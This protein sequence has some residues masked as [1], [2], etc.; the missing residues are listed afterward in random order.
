[1][2]SMFDPQSPDPPSFDLAIQEA[3]ACQRNGQL[4]EAERRYRTLLRA[5]PRHAEVN[6]QLGVLAVRANQ[7]HAALPLLRTALENNP[8][9]SEYWFTYIDALNQAGQ[10]DA[11][12]AMLAQG[13]QK[14]LRGEAVQRLASRLEV[15]GASGSVPQVLSVLAAFFDQSRFTEMEQ[16]ARRLTT[17]F[18]VLGAGWKALGTAIVMQG[19]ATE[20]LTPLQQA[21]ALSPEDAETHTN[22]GTLLHELGRLSEAERCYRLAIGLE[23]RSAEAHRHLGMTL[24][25][26]GENALA[27]ASCRRALE[28]MPDS[29]EA[30][31]NLASVLNA[32]G[33][34]R[35]A[36]QCYRQVLRM[37]PTFAEAYCDLATLLN[38]QFLFR[39]AEAGFRRALELK[40]EYIP[41]LNNLGIALNELGRFVEAEAVLRRAIALGSRQPDVLCN[42]SVAISGQGRHAEADTCL[43]DAIVANPAE[44]KTRSRRLFNLNYSSHHSTAYRLDQARYYGDAV[45]ASTRA[46][47][48][49]WRC[50]RNFS[51]V[52]GRL[53]VGL[54]SG[55]LCNH[56]VGYFL[57]S[58]ITHIDPARVELYAY[59]TAHRN[60]RLTARIRPAFAGWRPIAGVS[61][62]SAARIIH[63]DGV[64]ILV[65]LSGHTAGNRLPVFAFKP[66][67][68]QVSWLG[69][70]ATTGV[71]EID[72][73]IADSVSVDDAKSDQFTEVIWYLPETRLCFT[74]PTESPPV[75]SLPATHKGYVTFGCFQNLSKVGE[76]VLAVWA[77][78]LAALPGARLR[79]QCRELGYDLSRD[80]LIKRM[81]E[82][83]ISD[84]RVSL[85]GRVERNAYLASYREVDMVLD[86]FPYPGGTT[87][88]EALW[89]GVPTLTL[90]GDSL[91][92]R[93]GASLLTAAGLPDWIAASEASYL[94]QA[95]SRAGDLDALS[96][97]R[98]GLR[99]R[100]S[101][102]PLFD[103]PRFARHFEDA[104]WQIWR[105]SQEKY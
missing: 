53:R 19:R 82:H 76:G 92:T 24:Q 101:N 55:D 94:G 41:A 6:Y 74:P 12:R 84:D 39:D 105:R 35:E 56:P 90:A 96:A 23:P 79:M 75:A 71:G 13:Q 3:M 18:P 37:R 95:V 5:Q 38:E 81:R 103:A 30:L 33:R 52:S 32:Q 72:Y 10:R 57:E 80:Q 17:R 34:S 26:Q 68:V 104:L 97:L 28:L 27:E 99:E 31:C 29:A 14:G 47:Y 25:G 50:S 15:D 86:T 102:A 89:M 98:L 48:S 64:H 62:E 91:L 22:L 8:K 77:K 20:A 87:T 11:A 70:F 4:D 1:M 93:Q 21:A 88:C 65:D 42:L 78:I 63:A 51:A 54:V 100:V 49:E 40:P 46:R 36:E 7:V 16:A 69:Y 66:A 59:P 9:H 83:G 2:A 73:L 61:D 45:R 60:D 43:E 44:P 85:H 58:L 67:P